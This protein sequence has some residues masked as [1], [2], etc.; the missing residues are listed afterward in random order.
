[1]ANQVAIHETL[2]GLVVKMN[3]QEGM[4]PIRL[5]WGLLHCM[6]TT[7][8]IDGNAW[9]AVFFW[10]SQRYRG[11]ARFDLLAVIMRSLKTVDDVQVWAPVW[12][13]GIAHARIHPI[14]LPLSATERE[15]PLPSLLADIYA[16]QYPISG[17]HPQ[18]VANESAIAFPGWP[19]AVVLLAPGTAPRDILSTFNLV[20]HES[21]PGST[22]SLGHGWIVHG[23]I[24]DHMPNLTNIG[25]RLTVLT[26]MDLSRTPAVQRIRKNT[27]VA[28]P[29]VFPPNMST[30]SE[31][32]G[33]MPL[34]T[35]GWRCSTG[36]FCLIK[37]WAYDNQG[38]RIEPKQYLNS[39]VE[40]PIGIELLVDPYGLYCGQYPELEPDWESE[41][42]PG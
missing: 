26:T 27:L 1:M 34:P 2:D 36:V 33:G 5:I 14:S 28:G 7:L 16:S 25:P 3:E 39:P 13:A 35:D 40:W 23:L 38:Q 41:L 11:L 9:G 19:T 20:I 21:I 15:H 29:I 6:K 42:R 8:G 10:L 30:G 4:D 37:E 32:C 12:M 18:I 24:T 17:G 31:Q 22:H